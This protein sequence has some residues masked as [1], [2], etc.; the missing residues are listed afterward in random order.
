MMRTCYFLP[1]KKLLLLITSFLSCLTLISKNTFLFCNCSCCMNI[2]ALGGTPTEIRSELRE[3]EKKHYSCKCIVMQ[4]QRKCFTRY[5]SIEAMDILQNTINRTEL[6]ANVLE[7]ALSVKYIRLNSREIY[8][9]TRMQKKCN[10]SL[11]HTNDLAI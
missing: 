8:S 1:F 6:L 7:R 4:L 5:I 9:K 11:K 2:F 10:I 3:V